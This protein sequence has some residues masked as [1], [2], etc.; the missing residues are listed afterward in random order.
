MTVSAE[1]G[2][3]VDSKALVPIGV[4]RDPFFSCNFQV[5]HQVDNSVATGRL[6][7]LGEMGALMCCVRDIWIGAILQEVQLPN[8]GPIIETCIKQRRDGITSQNLGIQVQRLLG[9][10]VPGDVDI[11]DDTVNNLWLCQPNITVILILY[12]HSKVILYV[13][14]L[15]DV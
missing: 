13:F 4:K 7:V 15:F 12:V 11:A 14:L 5:F 6:R 3:D 9:R 2:I 10:C 1:V 8:N